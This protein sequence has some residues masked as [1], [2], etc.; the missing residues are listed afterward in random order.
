MKSRIAAQVCNEITYCS[1]GVQWNHYC[2]ASVQ[3]NHVLQFKCARKSRTA[4]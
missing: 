1:A 2:S 3:W 4:A